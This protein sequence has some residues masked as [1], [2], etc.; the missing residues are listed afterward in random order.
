MSLG[1]ER[2]AFASTSTSN[3]PDKQ[4]TED[5]KRI[6]A[7]LLASGHEYPDPLTLFDAARMILIDQQSYLQQ[8]HQWR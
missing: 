1:A 7:A 3:F 6:V 4:A 5:F 2:A 8:A